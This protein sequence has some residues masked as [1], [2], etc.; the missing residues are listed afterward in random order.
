MRPDG[1]PGSSPR[2][3]GAV[4]GILTRGFLKLEG[5]ANA[6]SSGGGRG[7]PVP[8]ALLVAK[9]NRVR[10]AV[11]CDPGHLIS[12]DEL[13]RPK[14]IRLETGRRPL[15]RPLQQFLAAQ[16]QVTAELLF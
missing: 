11:Q 12:K 8:S 1:L 10:V 15:Q 5:M 9:P 2:R 3:R 6:Y 14:T 7:R 16:P 13:R 4:I